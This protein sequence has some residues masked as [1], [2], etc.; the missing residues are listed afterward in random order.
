MEV[1]ALVVVVVVVLLIIARFLPRLAG[2]PEPGPLQH[3]DDFGT[4]EYA[5]MLGEVF[6]EQ[7][8]RI[9]AEAAFRHADKGGHP[10]AAVRR[11]LLMEQRGELVGAMVAYRRA[12]K[13]GDPTADAHL[14]RLIDQGVRKPPPPPRAVTPP[15][16][17]WRP[18]VH[19]EVHYQV[20][21][22]VHTCPTPDKA[23]R[24]GSCHQPQSKGRS[25]SQRTA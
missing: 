18:T 23:P 7:G 22:E 24:S 2:Q 4:P 17:T 12:V 3:D 20:D 13:R 21:R 8:D 19:N 11:G 16:P 25:E 5:F 15:L 1:V 6:E 10:E 14:A 9:R